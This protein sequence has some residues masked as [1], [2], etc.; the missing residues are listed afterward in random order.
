MSSLIEAS[1]HAPVTPPLS[2]PPAFFAADKK[3]A[4]EALP[5]PVTL[6]DIKGDERLHEL[7]LLKQSRLSVVPI[8]AASWKIICA[9][10]GVDP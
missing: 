9:M 1:F 4:V 6:D 3:A 10:G 8:D 2:F 7:A 5:T